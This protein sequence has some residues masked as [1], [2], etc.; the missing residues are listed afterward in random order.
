[1]LSEAQCWLIIKSVGIQIH[2]LSKYF[3]KA[4]TFG[5]AHSARTA[6]HPDSQFALLTRALHAG[7]LKERVCFLRGKETQTVPRF[8]PHNQKFQKSSGI[9]G[10]ASKLSGM[11]CLLQGQFSLRSLH[12]PEL[13]SANGAA[14]EYFRRPCGTDSRGSLRS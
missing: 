7:F 4:G 12:L 13:C 8:W 2:S 3:L 11:C 1:M 6:L 10:L 9:Y 14:D 5:G